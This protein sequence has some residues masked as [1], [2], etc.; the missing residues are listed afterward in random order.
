MP[1]FVQ[2]FLLLSAFI[3]FSGPQS[4]SLRVSST[5]AQT[6]DV[7]LA[8]YASAE[9]YAADRSIVG[10]VKPFSSKAVSFDLELPSAGDYV[11]SGYHDV[12]GNG[13]LDF[14]MMGIP[15]EPYGFVAPP[16]NKWREPAFADVATTVDAG[17]LNA[18]ME[19]K[20]WK[21]Y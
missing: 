10:A 12:N 8:V 21:E 3:V 4:I 5:A 18:R 15:K 20:H 16:F 13:K 9:D 17:K 6:G 2:F 14:N 11:I 19:F 7:H 1:P